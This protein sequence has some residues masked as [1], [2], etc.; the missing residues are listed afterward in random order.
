M[1]SARKPCCGNAANVC[2]SSDAVSS[3]LPDSTRRFT[4]PICSASSP[5]TPRP[6]RIKSSARPWPIMRGRRTVPRSISGTPKR[7]LNTPNI[8]SRAAMRRSH[9][10]A[11]SSPPATAWPSTAA[12]TGLL[13]CNHVG[14]IGPEPFSSSAVLR[15]SA[16][17]RRSA[18]AQKLPPTPVRTAA[19]SVS[20]ASNFLKASASAAAVAES[21]ALRTSGR[22]MVTVRTLPSRLEMTESC[23]MNFLSASA[24]IRGKCF[25]EL[26][27][28]SRDIGPR[29]LRRHCADP[30]QRHPDLF[31]FVSHRD[32]KMV[33]CSQI[34]SRRHQHRSFPADVIGQLR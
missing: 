33:F 23:D 5:E 32:A 34:S 21:T 28:H 26:S 15:P 12:I 4:R 27:P 7:R 6:V 16:T 14:P 2:A 13:N 9:H 1:R 10:N 19:Q 18:P 3:A 30:L 31:R 17:S 24:K 11:S 29:Q 25:S 8:A 22:L 20:S